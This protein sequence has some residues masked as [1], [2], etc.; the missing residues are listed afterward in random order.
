MKITSSSLFGF[1]AYLALTFGAVYFLFVAL[2]GVSGGELSIRAKGN[3]VSFS[4]LPAAALTVGFL[5]LSAAC[6]LPVVLRL[7]GKPDSNALGIAVALLFA[8]VGL[9]LAAVLL[10]LLSVGVPNDR[11]LTPLRVLGACGI[12]AYLIYKLR[13]L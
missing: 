2:Q 8:F 6:A 3:L 9:W 7:L 12:V 1:A 5:C 10:S 13:R 4:G 11:P